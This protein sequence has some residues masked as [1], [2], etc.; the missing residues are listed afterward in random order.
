[1]L[2]MI[3]RPPASRAPAG[4]IRAAMS[5]ARARS[6]SFAARAVD[7]ELGD[8]LFVGAAPAEDVLAAALGVPEYLVSLCFIA[9]S[10]WLTAKAGDERVARVQS[11]AADGIHRGAS[12]N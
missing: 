4:S 5:A 9:E 1:L 6:V 11:L 12:G 2:S 10:N 8:R 7:F 3:R